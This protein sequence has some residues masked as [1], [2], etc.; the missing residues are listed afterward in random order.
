MNPINQKH[1]PIPKLRDMFVKSL[2]DENFAD[3][4]MAGI[5]FAVHATS[6]HFKL[7]HPLLISRYSKIV[8]HHS[9]KMFGLA[10]LDI[11]TDAETGE[12]ML[13]GVSY[14][15]K[16]YHSIERP[17]LKTFYPVIRG[18]IDNSR[19]TN[20]VTWGSLDIACIIRLFDPTEDERKKI[21]RGIGG[22]FKNGSWV[23]MPPCHRTMPD[24][25]MFYIDHYISGR[26]LRLGMWNE[27]ANR[28]FNIWIYNISQFY[29]T[30]I[31]E[32]AKALGL[33]W[34]DFNRD[35]H[36]VNWNL[37]DDSETYKSNVFASNRQ[38]AETVKSMAEHLGKVFNS[39]FGAYPRLLVSAGSL[40]DSAVSALLDVEDYASNSW[41]YLT[42]KYINSPFVDMGESLLAE[43]YSAGY[44][45]QFGIG[46]WPE[47]HTAD[48]SSAYPHKIR[49][50]PDLRECELIAGKGNPRDALADIASKGWKAFTAVV[51]G[52]ATI[53]EHLK[54]H[55]ITVKTAQRQNIRPVGTFPASYMLEERDFCAKWGARF[56]EEQY[57][58]FAIREW[59]PAP[60]AQVSL[61]LAELRDDFRRRMSDAVTQNETILY[62]SMQYMVKVVDN[63][64]YGKNVMTTAIVEDID[65]KPTIT[66]YRAGDRFNMLYGAWI[67][68]TT[69]VQIAEACMELERKGSRPIMAMTDS[70]YWMGDRNHLPAD[71]IKPQKTAGYFEPPETVHDMYV[72]KTGQYE[73]RKGNKFY[74]KMRGLNIPYEVRS[75]S[76]S[77]FR[78]VIKQW[79][80]DNPTVYHAEDV[81]I[82]VDIRKL[83]SIGSTNLEKLGLIET[84]EA[85]MRPFV[86]S[87]K[88]VEPWV[89]GWKECIDGHVWLS[90][91]V[92]DESEGRDTPLNYLSGVYMSGADYLN[93]HERKRMFY[94]L[95]VKVTGKAR[96]PKRLSHMSWEELEEWS[97]V[98]RE[99]AN[100]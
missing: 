88:Q 53:P 10:G 48:I 27:S 5:D 26:S 100:M 80:L 79:M 11:E 42:S 94:L 58:I 86:L 6:A 90:L 41:R 30:T 47:V 29:E 34:N 71:W 68:A 97:G 24:G 82:P 23:A 77:Y 46:Y 44:V 20:I 16:F 31:A 93:R 13:I 61:K 7:L 72:V 84:S 81:E 73:Y 40:A 37:F 18:L 19:G 45:D 87:G 8:L 32:T 74:H 64:L 96:T 55:P 25:N 50:L 65:G 21:S 69:R 52:I 9:D 39:V 22:N 54:Y 92:L 63:S 83:V 75:D 15:D 91:N 17:A 38:D 78:R 51:S 33:P 98:K 12:P 56:T 43:A 95:C 36:I 4:N 28:A 59:K 89:E 14:E 70:V 99:W 60:I 85:L 62:D 35:T 57:V 1:I 3:R 76:E 66:G 2:D 49:Q 67:T